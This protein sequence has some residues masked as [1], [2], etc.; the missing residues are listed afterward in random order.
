[1][2]WLERK[3]LFFRS[4]IPILIPLF[5]TAYEGPNLPAEYIIITNQTLESA[6]EP[7]AEY[8]T[9]KGVVAEIATVDDIVYSQEYY[10][11][12]SGLYD[13]PGAIRG[14]L[15]E[16]Y[17]EGV[18]WV[19]LGG[20]EDVVPV[21]YGTYSR[22]DTS[23]DF[24]AP[25]D[26]YYSDLDGNWNVDGDEFLGEPYDDSVDVFP[27]LYVGRI[28]CDNPQEV[29]NWFEKLVSYETNPGR[30]NT[31]YLTKFL[32]TG[33]DDVRKGPKYTIENAQ[34]PGYILHDTTLLEEPD[35]LE[36]RGSDVIDKMNNHF[37]LLYSY[38]HGSPDNITI[39]APGNNSPSQYRDFLSSL[40]SVDWEGN[41][42]ND[43]GNGLDNLENEGYYSIFSAASCF[44]AAFDWEK[45]PDRFSNIR[46][47][48]MGEIFTVYPDVG[49]PAFRG[50]TR[51]GGRY[52]QLAKLEIS[53]LKK[54]FVDGITNIG[55]AEALSKNEFPFY[56]VQSNHTLLGC[57]LMRV[58]TATPSEFTNVSIDETD[59]GSITINTGVS[60]CDIC[61]CSIDGG[62]TYYM[63][64]HNTSSHTFTTS[65]RPLYATIT[66]PN[67]IPYMKILP[68]NLVLQNITVE[69]DS[70][71]TYQAGNS[72]TAAG[73]DT[74]FVIEG[75]GSTGGNVTMQAGDY[76]SLLP[77]FTAQEGC[78]FETHIYNH[79]LSDSCI[80]NPLPLDYELYIEEDTEEETED[81]KE[82]N[83]VV[84][85]VFSCAQ[86]SPNP[87]AKITA[88]KYGLPEDVNV[89][90]DIYNLVGQKVRTLVDARQSAGF[91]QVSWD[92]KNSAGTQVPQGVYFY[93]F[94]AGD[95][96]K[97]HKM[98]LLK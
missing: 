61:V 79:G 13:A 97:H 85:T 11:N 83:E 93:V 80:A 81:K 78:L 59:N 32:W 73:D 1:M 77:G 2:D 17:A 98:I 33:S 54:L 82:T 27:E 92:G 20:D 51:Y 56:Y 9:R 96:E 89:S 58:W 48:C 37:G 91:K 10:D 7:V 36:P 71:I 49:G 88:I 94:K 46:A 69:I 68:I 65:E 41:C 8:I 67:Y 29:A 45:F 62:A 53:F 24:N 3:F 75:N 72:I 90:L 76:I 64:A 22:N 18:T 5:L 44:Q 43:P 84:P 34:L 95:F 12:V 39:S 30:G 6:F 21:R 26:L 70:T 38:G 66:K 15:T 87:F 60:G 42:R 23:V 57:P 63:V 55:V 35:G 74:Y 86:N 19:L 50:Y 47:P 14:Y 4:L 28:P 40:D 16:K 52:I 31:G 25:S